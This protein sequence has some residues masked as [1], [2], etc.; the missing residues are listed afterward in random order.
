MARTPTSATGAERG[1]TLV[2]LL[3]TLVIL[4]L[5]STAVMLAIPG[6]SAELRDESERLAARL[7]ATRDAAIVGGRD[8]SVL[9]DDAGYRFEVRRGGAWLPA[10]GRA[11]EARRWPPGTAVDAGEAEATRVVFDVTGLAT[12][13]D[14][15]LARDGATARITV[16]AAG[17][18]RV[19]AR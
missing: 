9:V 3:V 12:P 13:A 1:F 5:A 15:R 10:P 16:G 17:E 19:D 2:E 6:G 14:V 8:M 11:F 7:A 4:G 18:V